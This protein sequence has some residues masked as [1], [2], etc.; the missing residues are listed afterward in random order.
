MK[1]DENFIKTNRYN[2]KITKEFK[3]Y[4]EDN[5]NLE[6]FNNVENLVKL[7]DFKIYLYENMKNDNINHTKSQIKKQNELIYNQILLLQ[8]DL[9][10]DL[11]LLK[12]KEKIIESKYKNEI[13]QIILEQ[14]MHNKNFNFFFNIK[15]LYNTQDTLQLLYSFVI[16]NKWLIMIIFMSIGYLFY[17]V[18]FAFNINY[19]PSINQTSFLYILINASSISLI[20]IAFFSM[21]FLLIPYFYYEAFKDTFIRE[22]LWILVLSSI[23]SFGWVAISVSFNISNGILF[24]LLLAALYAL[25]TFIYYLII[26]NELKKSDL[27]AIKSIKEKIFYF[28]KNTFLI[29]LF[30]YVINMLMYTA[31]YL[32]TKSIESFFVS[33][34]IIIFIVTIYYALVTN[35]DNIVIKIFITFFFILLLFLRISENFAR[36]FN[37]GNMEYRYL[38]MDKTAQDKMPRYISRHKCATKKETLECIQDININSIINNILSYENNEKIHINKDLKFEFFNTN[39]QKLNI[40]PEKIISYENKT[41][42]YMEDNQTKTQKNIIIKPKKLNKTYIAQITDSTIYLYNIKV[43]SNL[44]RFY[45]IQTQNGKK[46]EILSKYIKGTERK[47]IVLE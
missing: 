7:L 46:F 21:I 22:K 30:V 8:D 10:N 31:V 11:R 34:F 20:Y 36:M 5:F 26:K 19:L 35:I 41:L 4:L 23:S 6:Y 3:L 18:Y 25:S 28:L 14:L 24:L 2:I 9:K 13:S 32:S 16:N 27:F 12:N 37:I 15:N 40:K 47:K 1:T 42:I 38:A 33:Y 43:L 44:G 17:I 45:Y 39:Q 29:F